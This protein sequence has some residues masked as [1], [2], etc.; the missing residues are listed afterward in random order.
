MNDWSGYADYFTNGI[1]A[2]DIISSV[3][4]VGLCALGAI[5]PSRRYHQL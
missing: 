3:F 1:P 4:I 5:V 2:G